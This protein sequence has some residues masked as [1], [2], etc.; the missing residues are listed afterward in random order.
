MKDSPLWILRKILSAT[1]LLFATLD[2]DSFVVSCG[3]SLMSKTTTGT[4]KVVFP[5]HFLWKPPA[6]LSA[7]PAPLG[8]GCLASNTV[9]C[10]GLS[11]CPICAY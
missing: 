5:W 4:Y 11:V 2:L 3:T 10:T 8:T 7:V 9:L 1:G 6:H